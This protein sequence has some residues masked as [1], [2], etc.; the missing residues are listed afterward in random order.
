MVVILAGGFTVNC[1]FCLVLNLKNRTAGDYVSNQAPLLRNYLLSAAAGVLWYGQFIFLTMGDTR[2][3]LLRY[4]SASMLMTS[5][6]LFS[7]I[8]G[9]LLHEWKGTGSRTRKL[10]ASGLVLLI[11][12][13][14]I[15]GFGNALEHRA[16]EPF[17]PKSTGSIALHAN[18]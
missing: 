17:Q 7:T 14:V 4:S 8:W 16:P 9:I 11:L 3:G 6:I 5:M 12:S 2:T 1:A 15:T 13:L 18:R 10:L